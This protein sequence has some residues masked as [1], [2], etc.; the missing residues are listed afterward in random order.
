MCKTIDK[1]SVAVFLPIQERWPF[2]CFFQNFSPFVSDFHYL[3]YRWS[4]QAT[5]PAW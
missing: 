1:N 3:G 2:C 5:V 4:S